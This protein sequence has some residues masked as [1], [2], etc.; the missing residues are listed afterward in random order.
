MLN[1]DPRRLSIL[2]IH[3]HVEIDLSAVEEGIAREV[4]L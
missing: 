4:R 1:P 2:S 3:V